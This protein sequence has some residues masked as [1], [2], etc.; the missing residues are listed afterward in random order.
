MLPQL[1]KHKKNSPPH[2]S[3]HEVQVPEDEEVG[4]QRTVQRVFPAWLNP[5]PS[6]PMNLS[7]SQRLVVMRWGGGEDPRL[8]ENPAKRLTIKRRCSLKTGIASL[9]FH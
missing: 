4:T 3:V 6:H 9:R 2:P 5:D 8:M 1:K 7:P